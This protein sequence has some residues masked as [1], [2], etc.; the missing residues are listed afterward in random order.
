MEKKNLIISVIG[1]PEH[2]KTWFDGPAD[3]CNY[4][5]ILIVYNNLI[6]PDEIKERCLFVEYRPGFKFQIINELF[7]NKINIDDYEYFLFP[8]DDIEMSSYIINNLF[9]EMKNC[10]IQ[11]M[12]PAINDYGKFFIWHNVLYKREGIDYHE[13]FIIEVMVPLMSRPFL[14]K[15]LSLYDFNYTE[16]GCDVIW[17]K[18]A[19]DQGIGMYVCD[20]YSCDHCGEQTNENNDY[21]VNLKSQNI[22]VVKEIRNT[23]KRYNAMGYWNMLINIYLSH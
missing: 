2:Y 18:M 7:K 14:Q 19:A 23:L 8:D 9:Q 21:Y 15:F 3:L 22:N 11:I 5:V 12:Q 17:S 16:L 1:R 6:I 20:K 4:D 10:N 13:S